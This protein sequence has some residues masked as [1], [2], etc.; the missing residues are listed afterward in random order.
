MSRDEEFACE[1]CGNIPDEDGV[2]EHGR[3]CYKVS[4]DGGGTEYIPMSAIER[5]RFRMKQTTTVE[6][7]PT[8][9][10]AL[11]AVKTLL[12]FVGEDPDREG[13]VDTPAR[14]LKS[15]KE[16]TAGYAVDP[17]TILSTTFAMDSDEM[18]LLKGIQFTSTC[19]HHLLPFFG[20]ASVAYIPGQ[21]KRVVG[22]SKLARLVECYAKR[23]QL[24]ERMTDQIA[25]ALMRELQPK[26][27]GCIIQAEHSCMRCRG[28]KLSG[29]TFVTSALRGVLLSDQTAR[30]EFLSLAL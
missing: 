24:Q 7:P 3:G 22:L 28:V 5:E 11:A 23:L 12:R 16:M 26:G 27:A 29:T 4:E 14:V 15:F 18:I 2:L 9:E 17:Q 6:E 10:V 30:A 21:T 19:E 20:K 13:L 8:V 25:S 1:I